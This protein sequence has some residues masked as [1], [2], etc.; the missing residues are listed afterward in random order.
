MLT[1]G[2]LDDAQAAFTALAAF[3]TD[4][5]LKRCGQ[6]GLINVAFARIEQR[7]T[8]APAPEACNQAQTF[9]DDGLLD[10]AEAVYRQLAAASEMTLK[11]C[12]EAGF[13]SGSGRT[14]F[15]PR[16]R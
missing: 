3:D 16:R 10:A 14:R 11:K 1:E 7:P 12:G 2:K 15:A 9:L 8:P 6:T 5:A 4:E 13:G